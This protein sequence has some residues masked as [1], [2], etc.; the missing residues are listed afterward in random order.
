MGSAKINPKLDLVLDR[1]I[2]VPAH[3]I[4]KAWT[5]PEH[6]VKWFCPKPYEVYQ[7]EV[8]L[9]PGGIF[10]TSMRGPDLP[11]NDNA[12]SGCILEV[13][14]HEKFVW[15]STMGPGYRPNTSFPEGLNFTAFIQLESLG[16]KTRYIA[17]AS[18]SDEQTAKKHQEMGFTKGWG[19]A[20]DQM[21]EE[22]K[23]GRI[24]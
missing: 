14:K 21:I 16:E 3:L 7:C 8:D 9:K 24:K 15:T 18:H 1:S 13:A 2:D 10:R 6:I 11:E 20:L 17:I 12:P 4:W 19:I 5:E 23:Q 22:I